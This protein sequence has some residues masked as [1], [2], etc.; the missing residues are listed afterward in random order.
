M[1]EK[2]EG[3][4]SRDCVNKMEKMRGWGIMVEKNGCRSKE[5][6]GREKIN[7]GCLSDLYGLEGVQ[8]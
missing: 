8:W 4:G 1:L 2:K 5:K 6:R 7:R 3:R